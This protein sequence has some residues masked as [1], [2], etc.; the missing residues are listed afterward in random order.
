MFYRW[1]A[2]RSSC[3]IAELKQVYHPDSTPYKRLSYTGSLKHWITKGAVE[4][5]FSYA[6]IA[7]TGDTATVYFTD[8]TIDSIGEYFTSQ[9]WLNSKYSLDVSQFMVFQKHGAQW[10]VMKECLCKVMKWIPPYAD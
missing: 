4:V 8:V 1:A 3:N 2:A 7:I 10:K 6:K 5:S 9:E